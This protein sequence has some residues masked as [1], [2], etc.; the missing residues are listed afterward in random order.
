MA[1]DTIDINDLLSISRCLNSK[2]ILQGV[3][4]KSS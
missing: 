2:I 4:E 3:T 1:I